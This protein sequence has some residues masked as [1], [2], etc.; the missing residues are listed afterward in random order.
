M[1]K[2]NSVL[3]VLLLSTAAAI[4]QQAAPSNATDPQQD[5][6]KARLEKR[7]ITLLEQIVSDAQGLKLAENKIR[8]NTIAGDLLW[9]KNPG[10][11]RGLLND[12]GAMLGQMLAEANRAERD[13]T[14]TLNQL[15]QELVLTAGRHDGELGYQLLRSTQPQQT[16]NTNAPFTPGNRR[17]IFDQTDNLEQRL[18]NT[19]A[20]S[21]PA[22]AYQKVV[23]ALDKGEFPNAV[24]TVMA[25]LE[26]KD[27]ETFKKLADK[28]LNRLSSDTL[29]ANRQA[30]GLALSLLQPWPRGRAVAPTAGNNQNPRAGAPAV[31]DETAYHDLMNNA[32]AAGLSATSAG[33]AGNIPRGGPGVRG[34]RGPQPQQQ[35][36]MSDEA[37]RQN[38][39]R[40]LL[41]SLQ[42]MMPQIEQ[43]VPERAAAVK[44]KLADLGFNNA[45]VGNLANQMRAMQQGSSDSLVTAAG[46]APPQLQS[47]LYQQAAQRAIEEGNTER[48]VQI[49]NE[50]LEGNS[51]TAIMQAVDF[52]KLTTTASPEKLNEIKQKLAALATDSERVRYLTE[53]AT[54]TQKE[55]QKLAIRFLEDARQLVS[56]RAANYRDFEDQLRVADAY[57][58]VDP[59]RSFEIIDGGIAQLNELLNAATVLNGFEVNIYKEGELS[60]R[61]DSDLVGMVA[62]FGY[63][64][65]S[66]AKLDFEGAR[67]TA[68]KFQL[69]EPRMNARLSIVQS[70]LG[71][72]PNFN[73]RRRTDFPFFVR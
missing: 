55:N 29:L 3:L 47:R 25:R 42:T 21:D 37:Q 19:I 20:A 51:R 72:Q 53:L 23:E 46:T 65:S 2:K 35:P 18:L 34:V 45:Q 48:A 5:E 1:F 30:T 26:T 12:A 59:K 11:A 70:I 38:N 15:R 16:A 73:N 56:K 4:G 40:A 32:I 6:E 54:A 22:F 62:R 58:P 7:A 27:P 14:Q 10:R 68:D 17:F 8:V 52:K 28:T 57:G 33:P 9:D 24:G 49:A 43:Y 69:P 44:Q 66:L 63:Q 61:A 64:L 31:L 36:N 50:H 39:A 13:E 41:F 60:M 71:T 67:A